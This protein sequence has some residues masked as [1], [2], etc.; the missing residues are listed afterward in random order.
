MEQLTTSDAMF[1]YMEHATSYGHVGGLQILEGKSVPKPRDQQ[2]L[3]DHTEAFL[4]MVPFTRR[5]LVELPLKLGHPL[6]VNDPDFDLE[7]HVRQT[8]IPAP[9]SPR[10]VEPVISRIAARPLDR[11]R[12]MWEMYEIE[13]ID[14][15]KRC[16]VYTKIH[17]CAA[18]GSAM[19]A[20][21]LA[22]LSLSPEIVTHARPETK[23]EPDRLPNQLELMAKG[24]SNVV[25][26]PGHALSWGRRMVG[27]VAQMLGANSELRTHL[28]E[29]FAQARSMRAPSTRFGNMLGPHRR[30]AYGSTP[31][32]ELKQIKTAFGVTLNDVVLAICGGA[33]REWLQVRDELPDESLIAMV[34]V[35]IREGDAMEA[36]NA[37]SAVG[38]KLFTNI[39]D[40]VERLG[41]VSD[42]MKAQKIMNKA[43]P[44]SA[45]I[46]AMALVPAWAMY[47]A[48]RLAYRTRQTPRLSPFNLTIS[49]VPGPPFPVYLDGA[50]QLASYPYSAI[51][52]GLGLNITVSSYNGNL[53]WGI[54][55]DADAVDELWSMFDGIKAAQAELLKLA[56]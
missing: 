41:L 20:M 29:I 12:P 38:G 54:V 45:Q 43:V 33:L 11:T 44:A 39:A 2:T 15:G 3:E 26:R 36:G 52:D 30:F 9:G 35:N 37:I 4:Q 51:T 23:W 18:D 42:A 48:M 31:L 1:L 17:H 25:G 5:R 49:N 6:W 56:T 8:A 16:G 55:A 32:D 34:P 14:K 40:P 24:L 53:D 28:P 50:Q 22:T 10:Q 19:M 27:D 13:G 46:D 7:Y 47:T 21:A